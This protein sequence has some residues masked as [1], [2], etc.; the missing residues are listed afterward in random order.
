MPSISQLS[1][2]GSPT[3]TTCRC[4]FA[5]SPWNVSCVGSTYERVEQNTTFMSMIVGGGEIW[6]LATTQKQ[7]R[8]KIQ[9][10]GGHLTQCLTLTSFPH[11]PYSPEAH[12]HLFLVSKSC[13]FI[14]LT[15]GF[16]SVYFYFYCTTSQQQTPHNSSYCKV[17]ALQ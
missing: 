1:N 8:C 13:E 2:P 16:N 11:L 12:P 9:S 10:K 7:R 6:P 4:T 17:N 5:I 14:V 3:L 15:M